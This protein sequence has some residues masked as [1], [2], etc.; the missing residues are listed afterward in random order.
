MTDDNIFDEFFNEFD[1]FCKF[2][3]V[4]DS[5]ESRDAVL[6]SDKLKYWYCKNIQ[7][8][9]EVW[10]SIEGDDWKFWYC[11]FVVARPELGDSIKGHRWAYSYRKLIEGL[12]LRGCARAA[13][14]KYAQH[15]V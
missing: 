8:R 1:A 13:R 12:V 9:E 14:S 7:D 15:I 4:S 3:R 5:K 10:S 2:F 11:K 6:Q